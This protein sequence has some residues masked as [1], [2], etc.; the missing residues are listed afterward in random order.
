MLPRFL[1]AGDPAL[2]EVSLS[3]PPLAREL[4]LLTRSDVQTTPRIRV[5]VDFLRDLI[6]R[7]QSLFE[8][9]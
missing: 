5:V 8:G 1:A 6:G 2:V 7:E 3:R 9:T 4:W